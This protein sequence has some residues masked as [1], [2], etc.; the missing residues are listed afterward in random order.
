M[1]ALRY[2][3]VGTTWEALLERLRALRFRAAIVGPEG[4]GKT[5]LLDT[6][7]PQL[8]AAGFRLRRL[9]LTREQPRFPKGFLGAL[10][11]QLRP[12]VLMILDGAELLS[13]WAWPRFKLVSR[14]AGGLLITS[15][16]AG[17]LPTLHECRPSLALVDE[18]VSELVG[19][20]T[21]EHRALNQ[22]LYARHQG[23]VRLVLRTWYDIYAG[24]P[25]SDSPRAAQFAAGLQRAH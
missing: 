8:E 9:R 24:R 1:D 14:R 23:N 6:W 22:E 18:L 13:W 10:A 7:S 11:T 17:L 2:R 15:H 25:P 4:S 20:L 3:L 16:R 19:P 12:E 21:P 5:T